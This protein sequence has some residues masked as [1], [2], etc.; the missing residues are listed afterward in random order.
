MAMVD[1][2]MKGLTPDQVDIL[3]AHAKSNTLESCLFSWAEEAD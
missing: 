1:D 3:D 2:L